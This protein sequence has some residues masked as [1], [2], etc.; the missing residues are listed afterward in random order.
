LIARL[1]L[2]YLLKLS[3]A[4]HT[5]YEQQDDCAYDRNHYTLKVETGDALRAEETKDP[6]PKKRADD[7][8]YDVGNGAHLPVFPHDHARNPTR[9]R[10]EDDPY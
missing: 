7:A 8:N 1:F 4:D 5:N 10:S 2:F 6:T 9:E 3:A